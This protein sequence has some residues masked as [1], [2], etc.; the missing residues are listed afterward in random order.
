MNTDDIINEYLNNERSKEEYMRF[1]ER[2]V[3]DIATTIYDFFVR[4]ISACNDSESQCLEEL[5]LE[6][7]RFI[8]AAIDLEYNRAKNEHRN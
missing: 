1:M 6:F 2:I 3:H 7:K 8:S 4:S 5:R